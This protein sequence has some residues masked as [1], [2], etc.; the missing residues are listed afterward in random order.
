MD[1]IQW[2]AP[3]NESDEEDK[4]EFY[5][6]LVSIIQARPGRNIIITMGDFNA[7]IGSDNQGYKVIMGQQRMGEI[8][9]N[10]E[11][12]ANLC[13]ISNLVIG[14]EFLPP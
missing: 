5:H 10:G 13:A 2:Y 7:K 11:R 6:R 1:I 12:F 4:D 14:G 8:N 9:E 3:T